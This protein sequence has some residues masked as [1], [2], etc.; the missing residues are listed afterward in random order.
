MLH[1]VSLP[2]QWKSE[3]AGAQV[4]LEFYCSHMASPLFH[5]IQSVAAQSALIQF[6]GVRYQ[7]ADTL[8]TD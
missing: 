1:S 8:A 4:D 5:I 3:S 7:S 6:I 2:Y